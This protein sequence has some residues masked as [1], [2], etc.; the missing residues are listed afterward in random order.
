MDGRSYWHIRGE[1]IKP[2][3]DGDWVIE[4]FTNIGENLIDLEPVLH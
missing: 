3:R 2:A 4:L 1:L